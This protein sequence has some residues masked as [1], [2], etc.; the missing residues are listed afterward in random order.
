MQTKHRFAATQ[1][2]RLML[3]AV[4]LLCLVELLQKPTVANAIL[5]FCCAGAVPGTKI[6]LSPDAV[7]RLVTAT[8]ALGIFAFCIGPITRRAKLRR[9]LSAAAAV[10][11]VLA[12]EPQSTTSRIAKTPHI[13]AVGVPAQHSRQ[14]R[15]GPRFRFALLA[16]PGLP[17]MPPVWHATVKKTGWIWRCALTAGRLLKRAARYAAKISKAAFVQLRRQAVF[18]IRFTVAESILFWHWLEPH[19]RRFDAWLERQTHASQKKLIKKIQTHED[20]LFVLNIMRECLQLVARLW[21]VAMANV[22]RETA[23]EPSDQT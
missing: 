10:A 3:W 17:W 23:K 11:V 19:L 7:L 2:Q 12:A 13:R 16:L 21:S 22:R 15:T 14:L 4:S 9:R 18:G 20:A 8:L 1:T 5:S 6:V